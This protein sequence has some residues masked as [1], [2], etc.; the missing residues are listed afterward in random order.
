MYKIHSL[1]IKSFKFFKDINPLKFNNKNILI[2]GENGSGKSSIYWALYTFFQSGLKRDDAEIKKYFIQSTEANP[3]KYSLVNIYENNDENSKIEL[4]LKDENSS[5]PDKVFRISK[6]NINTNK[7]DSL[8]E[9]GCYSGDFINYKYIFRFFDFLHNEEINLFKLFE[10][11]ILHFINKDGENLSDLWKEIIDLKNRNPGPIRDREEFSRLTSKLASFNR[12]LTTVINQ[13]NQPSNEYLIKFNYEGLKLKLK[14][15]DG[16]YTK[17]K[18]FIRPIIDF[19]ISFKKDLQNNLPIHRS[20]SYFNEARLTAIA[21]SVRFAVTKI[22]LQE[23]DLKVLVLDD[24]LVSLDM[25]NRE[26]V[27]DLLINDDSFRDFQIIML[28][29]DKSFYEKS[30]RYFNFKKQGQWKYFEMYLDRDEIEKPYIKDLEEYNTYADIAKQHFDNK[31]YPAS[32][33]Y[34]RK[35][36]EK[37]FDEFLELDSLDKKIFLSKLKENYFK[38]IEFGRDLESLKSILVNFQH[39][40]RMPSDIQVEKCSLFASQINSAID[41]FKE[42]QIHVLDVEEFESLHFVLKDILHPQSHND[43]TRPLYKLELEKAIEIVREFSSLID[44]A[45]MDNSIE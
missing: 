1:N 25:S 20:Q 28:T 12:I 34:L 44:T 27:L 23:S 26:L 2:Y 11:E 33:N 13:I 4:I 39:C 18:K 7:D 32:A 15:V 35:E 31:D 17:Q 41:Q 38:I 21:L 40:S 36:V 30:K 45:I 22:K 19:S 10:Y 9:K 16:K 3:N 24:L 14:V 43:L 42:Y 37:R 6:E 29:H 8:I 5:N